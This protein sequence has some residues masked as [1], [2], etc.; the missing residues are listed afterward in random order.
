[1]HCRKELRA[2]GI[3]ALITSAGLF[4]S[5]RITL[6]ITACWHVIVL[7]W[8]VAGQL[9]DDS[10]TLETAGVVNGD[11]LSATVQQATIAAG[12]HLLY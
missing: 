11:T 9:L 8:S 2:T 6:E 1:M 12:L 3:T 5:K 7:A 10:C 4:A